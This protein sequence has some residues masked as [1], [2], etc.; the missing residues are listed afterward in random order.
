M[1][2]LAGCGGGGGGT[3][4]TGSGG[5]KFPDRGG[6]ESSAP[7]PS[8]KTARVVFEST[9]GEACC[10]ALPASLVPQGALLVLDDLPVGL[11][12]VTVSFFA[13]DFAP[14]AEGIMLSCKTIPTNLGTLCDPFRVASPSFTSQ[15]QVVNIVSGGQTN[16]EDL[17]ITA[18]PFVVTF[19]PDNGEIVPAPVTFD[20]T[21]ADPVTDV[22]PESV[23]LELTVQVPDG[24]VFRPITKR[25][26]LVLSPCADSSSEPCSL[27]GN[28]DLEGYKASSS[29]AFLLPGPVDVRILALNLADPPQ[30]VDFN[31]VFTAAPEMTP[32]AGP[33]TTE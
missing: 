11:A 31:Y 22:D 18:V 27:A 1:L 4:G 8:A 30:E 16:V 6:G 28:Q 26:P 3:S 14:S 19:S 29:P 5:S 10:I 7:P 12:T 21:V 32:A 17:I 25:L 24:P 33:E 13:E 15:P 2:L 9:N 20:F 23:A